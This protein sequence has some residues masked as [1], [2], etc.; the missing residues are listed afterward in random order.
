MMTQ[1]KPEI[2]YADDA[3]AIGIVKIKVGNWHSIEA[4]T[5]V[6]IF[7]R[8]ELGEAMKDKH[9]YVLP[10][11]NGCCRNEFW[12]IIERSNVTVL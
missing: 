12:K 3:D 10:I 7:Y 6:M 8:N 2:L 9:C 5:K 1:Q 4:G 11:I